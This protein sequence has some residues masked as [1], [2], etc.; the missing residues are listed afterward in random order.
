MANRGKEPNKEFEDE[1]QQ[2][3][4][5]RQ[6]GHEEEHQAQGLE[7]V[8]QNGGFVDER[9]GVPLSH[10]GGPRE[11]ESRNRDG[12]HHDD[13]EEHPPLDGETG[14]PK[15]VDRFAFFGTGNHAAFFNGLVEDDTNRHRVANEG[16]QTEDHPGRHVNVKRL[17]A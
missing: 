9:I 14:V 10:Q 1:E 8:H 5:D 17:N 15:F 2:Q 11:E 3:D 4:R 16:D 7:D 13:D 12:G 6:D